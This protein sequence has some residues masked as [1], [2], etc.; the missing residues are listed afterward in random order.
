MTCTDPILKS[1]FELIEEMRA[2]VGDGDETNEQ[3]IL[4]LNDALGDLSQRVQACCCWETEI[5]CQCE[6]ELP[7]CAGIR[8]V[9]AFFAP[10]SCGCH[11][12]C[13]APLRCHELD[14]GTLRIDEHLRG[15]LRLQLYAE[16]PLIPT[17][18]VHL[19]RALVIGDDELWI[20]GRINNM[21]PFGYLRVC[22]EWVKYLCWEQ[23]EA[24]CPEE[25]DVRL[26]QAWVDPV[27]GVE[28]TAIPGID[29]EVGLSV[30]EATPGVHTVFYGID[31]LCNIIPRDSYP[32]GTEVE[33][34]LSFPNLQALSGL[35]D[36]ALS[37]L[38]RGRL[39]TCT[40][41]RER[42]FYSQM[43]AEYRG[44]AADTW[45]GYRSGRKASVKVK[46]DPFFYNAGR[47][48][49]SMCCRYRQRSGV[50]W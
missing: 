5:C 14:C 30:A 43:F 28:E 9:D 13:F 46:S 10:E 29:P 42:D 15:T 16:N 48:K 34:G 11:E 18:A 37:N 35:R 39:N 38:Y 22:D 33:I 7:C 1:G 24:P 41:A 36:T 40:S 49:R 2:I 23:R 17:E 32:Q 21:P 26:E 25:W 4:A 31:R 8:S 45:R 6:V 20:E 47:R 44:Q 3:L 19:A 12:S 50:L 27:A